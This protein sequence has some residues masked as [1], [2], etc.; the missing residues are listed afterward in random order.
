MKKEE[1]KLLAPEK[2]KIIITWLQQLLSSCDKIAGKMIF[3]WDRIDNE[4]RC[5][6]HIYVPDLNL[7]RWIDLEITTDH[8]DIFYEQL[9][10]D[11]LDTFLEH[12]TM[13][14]SRYYT[15][16]SSG[17]NQNFSGMNTMNNI[18]SKIK[19][20]FQYTGQKFSTLASDYNQKIDNYLESLK[21]NQPVD[22]ILKSK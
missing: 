6:A 14:V 11:I 18:G 4:K 16:K 17:I 13:G 22:N 20:D 8:C 12:E 5:I 19:L 21:N 2:S 3:N 7:D 10:Q 1:A 9:F 15:I